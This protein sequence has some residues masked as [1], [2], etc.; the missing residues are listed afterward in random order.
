MIKVGIVGGTGYTGVEL[1]RLLSQRD[2]VELCCVTSREFDGQAICSRFPN[3]RGQ[4]DLQFSNPDSSPLRD[5]EV[6][7][8]ATP[9]G[10]AMHSVPQLIDAGTK[11]IDLSADF[12]IKDIALWE[13]WYKT[14]HACPELVETAVYGLPETNREAIRGAQLIAVPGCYPTAIQLGFLPLLENNIIDSSK[15]IADAKSGVSGAG[16]KAAED[17]LLCEATESLKAYG[18][19]GHRHHPEICQ[20]LSLA[21][22]SDV[23]LTFIP[24]LAPMSRGIFATLYAPVRDGENVSCDSLQTFFESRYIDEPFIEVL[25]NDEVPATRNVRGANNCQISV[26]YIANTKNIVVFSVI[27]NL[28]KGASGQAVQNMNLLLGIEETAGLEG[29]ALIP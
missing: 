28:V 16:R 18:I 23:R 7:F 29:I 6:V 11:V 10:V 21:A 8:F 15:L 17:Y 20:Q 4:V 24:H 5:C 19:S 9:H 3:L 14:E 27:D 22:S 26:T 2:D 25:P 12:R 13:H 1:L